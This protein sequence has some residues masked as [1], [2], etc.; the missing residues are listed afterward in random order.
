MLQVSNVTKWY[1]DECILDGVSFT[2]NAGERLGL[3]GPNGCGKTTLLD[4]IA[5][6]QSA[7]AGS[8]H[9][10]QPNVR[11]GYLKQALTYA[12]EQTVGQ[13]I[14]TAQGALA[15]AQQ[16]MQKL[17]AQLAHAPAEEQA[18]LLSQYAEAQSQFEALGG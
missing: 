7:D 6:K 17:A 5:G 2:V 8:V 13:V 14:I 18:R 16:R 1:G 11:M 4:I 3:V 15:Q 12:P 10:T 9:F